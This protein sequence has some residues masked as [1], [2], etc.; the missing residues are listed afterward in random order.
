MPQFFINSKDILNNNAFITKSSDIKHI[1]SVLRLS[2]G[3]KLL[4]ADENGISYSVKITGISG[5]SI[6]TLVLSTYD[7]GRKLKINIILAQSILKAQA[8][9]LFVQKA[10]ELGV[11][12]II[13]LITRYGVVKF[14]SDKDKEQKQDRW[15]KIAYESCKQCE[16]CDIPLVNKISSLTVILKGGYD[17]I[18]A[19]VERDAEKTVKRYMAE[20][21]ASL[22]GD[23]KILLLIGPEGGWSN[24][25]IEMLKSLKIPLLTLGNMILRAETAAITAISNVIYEYEL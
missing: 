6:K 5:N 3:D 21:K 20:K 25:E 9:D 23:T 19:C 7:S 14:H 18:I 4:L 1:R 10:T 16:R 11:R 17:I 2:E 24:E 22:T 13:P 8:Q 12:E 15:Q